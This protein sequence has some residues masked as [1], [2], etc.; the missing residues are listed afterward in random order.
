MDGGHT[1]SLE[2]LPSR[3]DISTVLPL[4]DGNILLIGEFGTLRLPG[5]SFAEFQSPP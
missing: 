4:A 5:D 3:Q 1:V 2:Q